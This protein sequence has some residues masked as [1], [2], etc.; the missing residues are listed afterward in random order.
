MR[1]SISWGDYGTFTA[2]DLNVY[3]EVDS[4]YSVTTT[5]STEYLRYL[6]TVL[7]LYSEREHKHQYRVA[8]L[9]VFSFGGVYFSRS[10]FIRLLCILSSFFCHQGCHRGNTYTTLYLYWTLEGCF[11]AL[12]SRSKFLSMSE[13]Q[14]SDSVLL[15]VYRFKRESWGPNVKRS[16]EG[17]TARI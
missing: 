15:R 7:M 17:Y 5:S 16:Q 8:K 12:H 14:S 9:I 10:N 4:C 1:R 6:P 3:R 13:S 11:I 2:H